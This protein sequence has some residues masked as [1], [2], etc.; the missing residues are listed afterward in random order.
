[1]EAGKAPATAPAAYVTGLFDNY[2]DEFDSHLVGALRYQAHRQLVDQLVAT[3]GGDARFESALDLGCGTGLC[4][5]LVRPV[6]ARL[7]GVD[8][9]SRMLDKAR[10]LAVYD[11]LAHAD[12]VE[13]LAG[14]EERFDL[15]LAAD[16]FIYVGDLE[17]VFARLERAMAEGVFCFSVESLDGD[18]AGLR[19]L[20]SLR[21]AHSE[22]YLE[23]LASQHGF[24]VVAMKHAPVREEQGQVIEGLYVILHRRPA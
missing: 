11:R 18:G 3:C 6:V 1:M 22:A 10:E 8:L 21:Y 23:R 9:S 2:A 24:Q 4:G 20:P 7:T 15:V 16:V 5:P 12:I 13:F 14:S 17:P 19:L